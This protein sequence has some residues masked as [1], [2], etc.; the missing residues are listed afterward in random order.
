MRKTSY[1]L[2]L[3]GFF[4]CSLLAGCIHRGQ[5]SGKLYFEPPE[6]L[7]ED[8]TGMV[9]VDE[10]NWAWTKP[11]FRLSSYGNVTIKPISN[12][13]GIEDSAIPA[14]IYDGLTAWCEQAG[15][16]LSDDG[17]ITCEGAIVEL[18][19]ERSFMQKINPF[20]EDEKD[21]LLEAEFIIKEVPTQNTLCKI[22]HGV[23]ALQSDQ[24]ASLLLS[25]LARYFDAHK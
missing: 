10:L 23:T 13:T 20:R 9:E 18:N 25:G 14:R 15:L 24:L 21:F 7:I 4:V 19:I 8:Y 5:L 17:Q 22:R 16:K 2:L 1:S 12:F 11:G 3:V 6:R